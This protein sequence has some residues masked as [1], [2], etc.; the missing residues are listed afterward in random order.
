[1]IWQFGEIDM[2]DECQ[3]VTGFKF[4]ESERNLVEFDAE[5]LAFG[6][7]NHGT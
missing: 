7:T 6:S 4:A 5:D 3:T 2:M 1:M